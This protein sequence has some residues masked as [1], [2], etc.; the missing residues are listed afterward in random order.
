[1]LIEQ[2]KEKILT[3]K[4]EYYSKVFACLEM[5]KCLQHHE[6]A[7]ITAKGEPKETRLNI[8]YLFSERYDY[9]MKHFEAM[10]FFRRNLNVYRSVASFLP[11]KIPI[12]SYN[13]AKRLEEPAYKD[14]NENYNKYVADYDFLLDVDCK[15][16]DALKDVAKIKEILDEFHLPYGVWTTS[17]KGFHFWIDGRWFEKSKTDWL[18]KRLMLFQEIAYNLQGIYNLQALDISIFDNKRLAKCPYSFVGDGAIAL[19]LTDE[20][21]NN[22]NP[23]I[24]SSDYVLKN[25]MIKNRGLLVR[26]LDLSEE[27]LRENIA[28]FVKEFK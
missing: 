25:V 5:V 22:F 17:Y 1:M 6:T 12:F 14:F 4:K 11:N 24:V 15:N 7:F 18:K 27:Q 23:E 16:S 21:F 26:N 13:L 20:Q 28:K 2:D 10:G 9:L 8:R 3:S 19:P